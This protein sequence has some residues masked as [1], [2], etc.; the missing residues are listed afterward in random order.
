MNAWFGN[1]LV[2]AGIVAIIVIRAPHGRRSAKTKIADSRKGRLEIGLLTLMWVTMIVLPVVSIASPLLSF[3]DYPLHPISFSIGVASLLAGLYLLYR[4]HAD[5]GRNWS[6]SLEI[7]E[8]HTL[9]TSGIYGRIRHPMYTAIFL[10]A[11]AQALLLPNWVAGPSC[12]L[13]F[14]T[15][16]MLRVNLEERMMLEK[17]GDAYVLYM[18]RTKRLIPCVW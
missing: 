8:G 18:K 10:Q 2:L 11:I 16:F 5:L 3:A 14:L 6:V 15:M 1:V 9:V 12:L 4:S 17:F 13:A 7:R